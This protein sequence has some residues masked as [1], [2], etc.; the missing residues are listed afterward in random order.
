MNTEPN[1]GRT[2]MW[3]AV[4]AGGTAAGV[5]SGIPWIS[6]LCCLWILGGAAFA[7]VFYA[8]TQPGPTTPGDGAVIGAFSGVV[9]AFVNVLLGV[10]FRDAN[11]AFI[12]K[13][14]ERISANMEGV[15][16]PPEWRD[17][18]NAAP[19]P[20]SLPSL[21]VGLA[22]AAAVFAALGAVGGVL[23][24]ALFARHPSPPP[25][26]PVPPPPPLGEPR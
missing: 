21:V 6:C 16:F 7:V 19:G 23:G 12:R 9:A 10:V 8:R 26:G 14:M 3:T 13:V 20:V 2:G 1:A 17:L 22:F 25:P 5:L 15:N 11:L 24:A 18:I 4:L